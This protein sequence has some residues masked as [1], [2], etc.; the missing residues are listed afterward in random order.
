[1]S[2]DVSRET[3]P[4]PVEAVE[5]FSDSLPLAV[6]L[7]DLLCGPGVERGLLGPREADRIWSRHLLN[8]AVATDGVETDS[9]V[10]DV[11]SGAGLPGLV[12]AIRRPDVRVT[13]IEPLLRRTEFLSESVRSLGLE[14]RVTVV[15]ARAEDA[16]GIGS[17]DVVTSRAVAPLRRLVPWSAP[18]CRTRGVI[19][20]MKGRSATD[21]VSASER[22]IGRVSSERPVVRTYGSDVLA[23]PTTVVEIVVDRQGK[24]E[25]DGD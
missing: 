22:V 3:P 6:R 23:E 17:F 7:A 5:V 21:E 18:L 25:N 8:C 4:P 1:M 10:A 19:A 14:D 24:G 16:G 9:S 2:G 15:R 11:G 13:L 20:A 12:W